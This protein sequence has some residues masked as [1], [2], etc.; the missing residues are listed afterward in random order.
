MNT[1]QQQKFFQEAAAA[2]AEAAN[3]TPSSGVSS[4]SSNPYL[5][6]AALAQASS[7]SGNPTSAYLQPP[8]LGSFPVPVTQSTGAENSWLMNP[9]FQ[10]AIRQQWMSQLATMSA[11]TGA[12][13][14]NPLAASM[15]SLSGAFPSP[16]PP[17]LPLLIPTN[18]TPPASINKSGKENSKHA[19]ITTTTASAPQPPL[20]IA[21]TSSPGTGGSGLDPASM[22]REFLKNIVQ[23]QTSNNG[24]SPNSDAAAT[25]A[26]AAAAQA[27]ANLIGGA[28]VPVS[29]EDSN[30]NS[31]SAAFQTSPSSKMVGGGK[32]EISS[33]GRARPGPPANSG[34]NGRE[35]NGKDKV[36]TCA[37]CNRSFG[38]K[39][40][41]QNHERTHTGE[42]PFE[43]KVCH[44]RFTRD[45]H[46]KTHMRLH[47][48]E[49]PYSCTH[50]DRQFVQVA[51][52]RRHL[53]VHTGE[54][55][56]KCDVCLSCFS[57]S[58]QLKAHILIHKGEK[59]FTCD[60]CMG[61]FR[62]RHHLMHH[63]CP[64][65]PGSGRRNP[66]QSSDDLHAD[67]MGDMD[68]D[69]DER[70]IMAAKRARS[71]SLKEGMLKEGMFEDSPPSLL[72]RL[73]QNTPPS[74][75]ELSIIA[76]RAAMER[77]RLIKDLQQ[78]GGGGVSPPGL[79]LGGGG[80]SPPRPG[81]P[82]G[83]GT[84]PAT[85]GGSSAAVPRSRKSRD[86]KKLNPSSNSPPSLSGS[87]KME[88]EDFRFAAGEDT[89][90]PDLEAD[91]NSTTAP[92][93]QSEPED[94][95]NKSMKIQTHED[96]NLD[97][98]AITTHSEAL[99]MGAPKSTPTLSQMPIANK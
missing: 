90:E 32:S 35:Y 40:V 63:V 51:N 92:L 39:H 2:A 75:L 18:S 13:F 84:P 60:K 56:Y 77:N 49:K 68:T 86:P 76:A 85:A 26:A 17:R 58:N 78:G 3:R 4:V 27:M 48:G 10:A 45:H 70:L 33:G 34:N 65:V 11:A 41:L 5:A 62:R 46:L 88:G 98:M 82:L 7:I 44:K 69:D 15:A 80:V 47:T 16:V 12:P 74:E 29:K 55:P 20:S 52:L 87:I 93:P 28:A 1:E 23:Q 95:S 14:M 67:M 81:L 73:S 64:M 61:K 37:T 50:C 89:E 53:R 72:A 36:F 43:C 96:V 19:T 83:A 59:P 71:A 9:L 94:L 25:A 57:D 99:P 24:G 21:T 22:Y 30:G 66:Q 79:S 6:A 8:G 97:L 42:K 54:R 31:K 38:Y 91:D